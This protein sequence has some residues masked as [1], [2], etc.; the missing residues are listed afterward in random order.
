MDPLD[1][2]VSLGGE[3]KQA[4][5]IVVIFVLMLTVLIG[6]IG[7]AIDTTYAWRES[8]RVQRA[9]DAGALAGVVYMPGLPDTAKA[10]AKASAA[11][12]G[13]PVVANVTTVTPAPATDPRELDVTITTQ[14]PTF[15]SRIFGINA[16]TVSRMSK[17]VYVTPVPMGSPQAYYGIFQLCSVTDTCVAEPTVT[18]SGGSLGVSLTNQGFFGAIEG[19]GSNRSTGDAFA[20]YYNA[21]PTLNTQYTSDGYRYTIDAASNGV[22]SLF[23]PEFCATAA[24]TSTGGGHAGAGDHWIGPDNPGNTDTYY[25]L[26]DTHNLPLAPGAWTKVLGGELD[27]TAENNIDLS[28][29]Y[30]NA[31]DLTK[32]ADQGTPSGYHDCKSDSHHNKWVALANVSGGETYSLQVT[33]TKPGSVATNTGESFENMFSIAVSGG[34]QVYGTQSIVTYANISTGTTSQEFY[35]AQIDSDAGRG[36]T[37][38]INLFDPG[39]VGAPSWIQ[40]EPDGPVLNTWSPT[41]FAYTADNG[42]SNAST[43]CLQTYAASGGSPPTGCTENATSGGTLY[44][45]SWVTITITLDPTYGVAPGSLKN[46]SWWKIKYI[47]SEANDTTTWEVSILGNPVHLI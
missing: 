28:A 30:G 19:E 9:A 36:K 23:D 41:T 39:D 17:A 29:T 42:R 45:N 35:L 27:E 2:R 12:N 31:G 15:F 14:V 26:W 5:Q 32:Y 16:F 20:T 21:K 7:I 8:L 47:V 4:G 46:D 3:I 22:V 40:I 11:Q 10:T 34:G 44:Q 33:T 18:S 24:K 43:N 1:S 38:Q 6:L 13:F 25:I 37:I